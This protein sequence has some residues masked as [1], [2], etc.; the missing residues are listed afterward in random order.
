MWVQ[1]QTLPWDVGKAPPFTEPQ[2]SFL[3]N[4]SNERFAQ[5]CLQMLHGTL[6]P[7]GVHVAGARGVELL[8]W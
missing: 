6:L 4:G 8:S 1:V 3:K 7:P 2:F 5:H